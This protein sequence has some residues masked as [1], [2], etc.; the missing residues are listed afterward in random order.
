MQLIDQIQ[1]LNFPTPLP[2][3]LLAVHQTF[4][5]PKVD[6]IPAETAK[7]VDKLAANMKPRAS[8]AVGAGSRGI[9]NL[10]IIVR[11][12]VDRLKA[13]GMKPFIIPTMGSHGGAT[14]E[15]QLDVLANLGV[16][17][18]R[19][20]V[21]FKATMEV[22]EIGNL[23]NGTPLCQ[24]VNAMAADHCIL[25]SRIKPHTDFRSHLESGPS[26]MCVIGLGKQHGASM[27][28]TGGVPAFQQY[29]APAARIY[30]QN[31]N[32][33]G[34]VGIVENAYDETAIIEGLTAAE[35]G[36]APEERL[37]E[38]AKSLMAEHPIPCGGCA[39]HSTDWQGY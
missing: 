9:A 25:V 28:H 29:L 6:D 31:T 22:K 27:M 37:L 17:P 12:T 1:D 3:S 19:M 35:V 4:D 30:E 39:G 21:E 34:A 18:E 13:L 36:L 33:V 26:K 11:A 20:G 16:T 24:D 32:F 2:S 10:P 15:G 5:A 7:A 38:T 8:V 14:V 23:A